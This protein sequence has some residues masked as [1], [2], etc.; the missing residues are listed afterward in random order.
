MILCL[1]LMFENLLNQ[2]KLTKNIYLYMFYSCHQKISCPGVYLPH[3]NDVYLSISLFRQ[4][5][6]TQLSG[7]T[8]PLLY[9]EKF[10]FDKV[11]ID[12]SVMSYFSL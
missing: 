4:Y 12:H 11:S 1:Y 7:P 9:H 5:R 10:R 3:R 8:F 2:Y 6:R